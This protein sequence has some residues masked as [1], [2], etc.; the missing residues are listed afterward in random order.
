M[1]EKQMTYRW[2]AGEALKWFQTPNGYCKTVLANIPTIKALRA[3]IIRNKS[4]ISLMNHHFIKRSHIFKFSINIMIQ[5]KAMWIIMYLSTWWKTLSNRQWC[6][7]KAATEMK[8]GKVSK[9]RTRNH[10]PG[11]TI[12]SLEAVAT[13]ISKLKL[14]WE[15]IKIIKE[16]SIWS[17]SQKSIWFNNKHFNRTLAP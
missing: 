16:E 12:A 15:I 4:S 5:L 10:N 11:I 7:L 9:K 1:P 6:W 17:K 14:F 8:I 3:W 2:S 13:A